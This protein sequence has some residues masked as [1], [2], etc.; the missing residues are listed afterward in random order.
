MQQESSS[1]ISMNISSIIAT[2]LFLIVASSNFIEGGW[3][4]AETFK[5]W[6]IYSMPFATILTTL[7]LLRLHAMNIIER[8]GEWDISIVVLVTF[9][10]V[11]IIG[12]IDTRSGP[13][14]SKIFSSTYSVGTS[15]AISI[16]ILAYFTSFFR[17]FRARDAISIYVVIMVI[18]MVLTNTPLG[19]MISP[20]IPDF[21]NT[22]SIYVG[23]GADA[24]F[25][26]CAFMGTVAM[27]ARVI[28]WKERLRPD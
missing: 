15:A 10:V 3:S 27:L 5:T 2:I 19:A 6:L 11:F 14:Y 18:I 12:Y 24:A 17:I 23:G 26:A 8:R 21:G 1:K 25:R 4:P 13:I 20:I 16:G 28:L 9:V 7:F 22:V